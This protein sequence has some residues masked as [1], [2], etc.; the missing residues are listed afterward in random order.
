MKNKTLKSLKAEF[1][2]VSTNYFRLRDQLGKRSDE[3]NLPGLRAKYEGKFFRYENSTGTDNTWPIFSSCKK[4]LSQREAVVDCFET[5]PYENEFKINKNCFFHMFQT[6]I[7]REEYHNA[8]IEF[9]S[10]CL[11]LSQNLTNEE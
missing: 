3:A 6:E 2:R 7:T 4:V 9:T 1:K 5:T 8:L 11:V 10:K